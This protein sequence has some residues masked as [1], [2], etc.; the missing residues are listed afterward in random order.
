MFLDPA[1]VTAQAR[2]KAQD[3]LEDGLGMLRKQDEELA[4]RVNE[5]E[6]TLEA[7]RQMMVDRDKG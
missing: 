1:Y 2:K 6:L 4:L 5:G 7:A 3:W